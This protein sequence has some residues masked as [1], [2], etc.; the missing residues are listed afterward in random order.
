SP[1]AIVATGSAVMIPAPAAAARSTRTAIC[2]VPQCDALIGWERNP[3]PLVLDAIYLA[4][5]VLL[6]P[7]LIY[8]AMATGKR[9]SGFW[10]KLT[11][12][13]LPPEKS[14]VLPPHPKGA[15]SLPLAPPGGRGQGAGGPSTTE[16]GPTPRAWF[17]GVSVGEIH[18]LR[19]VVQEFQS[20]HP[21]WEC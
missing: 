17:H 11:G 2:V 9:P 4:G 1:S 14:R 5:L 15:A 16:P 3:M 21:D 20:R 19:Q 10:Q 13:T 12:S 6:A 7:W 18:L 8:R